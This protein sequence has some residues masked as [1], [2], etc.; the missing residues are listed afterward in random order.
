MESKENESVFR[1]P[2]KL[3]E[4]MSQTSSELLNSCPILYCPISTILSILDL[5]G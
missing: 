2:H 5:R 1:I 3:L 4:R